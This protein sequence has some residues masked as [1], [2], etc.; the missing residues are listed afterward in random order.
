[1]SPAL[2]AP[3][4]GKVNLD[5]RPRDVGVYEGSTIIILKWRSTGEVS[6]YFLIPSQGAPYS[7]HLDVAARAIPNVMLYPT[8]AMGFAAGAKTQLTIPITFFVGKLT[9]SYEH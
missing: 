7:L 6:N 3:H 2:I 1:M 8:P 5:G 4:H 9:F